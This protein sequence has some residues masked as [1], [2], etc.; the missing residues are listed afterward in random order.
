MTDTH[1]HT[2]IYI[3]IYI[4]TLTHTCIYTHIVYIYSH[5]TQ[6]LPSKASYLRKHKGRYGSDKKTRKKT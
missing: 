6:K 5:L 1:T 3:Y 2:H 4:Y